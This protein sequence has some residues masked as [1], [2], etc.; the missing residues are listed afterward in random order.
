MMLRIACFL[1]AAA[2][3]CGQTAARMLALVDS[4]RWGQ[5]PSG[6]ARATFAQMENTATAEWTQHCAETNGGIVRESFFY[7]FGEAGRPARMRVDVRPVDESAG[8]TAGVLWNWWQKLTA[9]FGAATRQPEMMEI[10]FR[11]VR[12]GQPVSGDHWAGGGLHYFLHANQ[13]AGRWECG[14]RGAI[15]RD[16]GPAVR[17]AAEGRADTARGGHRG[18]ASR[19]GR[20]SAAAAKDAHRTGLCEADGRAAADCGGAATDVS[21]EPAGPGDA[22]WGERPGGASAA[23]AVSAGGARGDEQAQPDDGRSGAAAKGCCG[24]RRENRRAGAQRRA[25][26]C[27]GAAVARVARVSG[28]GRRRARIPGTGAAGMEH[29]ERRG[30]S[31]ES[32]FVSRSDR[33]RRSISGGA[34]GHG[35]S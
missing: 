29:G 26:V 6:I 27:G 3:L 18:R 21:R 4:A 1:I 9:R 24:I 10:G 12:Y 25:G 2:P 32:G 31:A 33:A 20:P 23:R 7:V 17:G 35:F 34:P 14:A 16:R 8:T 30:V 22:A 5:N 28:D 13:S 11:H 19:G 15:D